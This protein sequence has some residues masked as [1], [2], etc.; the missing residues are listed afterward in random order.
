MC[1]QTPHC[2]EE[3]LTLSFPM[4]LANLLHAGEDSRSNYYTVNFIIQRLGSYASRLFLGYAMQCQAG[5]VSSYKLVKYLA[6]NEMIKS[7][8]GS[9][10]NGYNLDLTETAQLA[11]WMH[12]YFS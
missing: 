3:S 11:I 1:L 4:F 10:F 9:Y 2:R 5:T 12:H 8:L 6:Q 7:A